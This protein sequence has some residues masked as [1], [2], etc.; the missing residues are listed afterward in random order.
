MNLALQPC[1]WGD[2]VESHIT[3]VVAAGDPDDATGVEWY[4]GEHEAGRL[5]LVAGTVEN[6][7]CATAAY[8]FEQSASGLEMVIVAAG[9][10]G[11]D[12]Q[13]TEAFWPA[14]ETMAAAAGA[15]SVRFHTNRQ[16]L[17]VLAEGRGYHLA[18]RV[19]RKD[20]RHGR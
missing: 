6:V 14:L 9:G 3:A 19:M 7:H 15:V 12:I 20:L 1:P 8:R 18:E 10:F 4:R 2:A 13:L 17:I 5:A 11:D 16:G